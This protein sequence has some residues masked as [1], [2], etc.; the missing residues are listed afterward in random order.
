MNERTN[1]CMHLHIYASPSSPNLP[2]FRQS[3]PAFA[4]FINH[5][6]QLTTTPPPHLDH[7]F[8]PPLSLGHMEGSPVRTRVRKGCR[9]Q[10]LK[11]P[12]SPLSRQLEKIRFQAI[13]SP[14]ARRSDGALLNNTTFDPCD[15][16][17]PKKKGCCSLISLCVS[18]GMGTWMLMDAN[19]CNGYSGFLDHAV[20][21]SNCRCFV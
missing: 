21:R 16:D 15:Q 14:P 12:W 9:S 13:S 17:L 2:N 11:G 8:C 3:M 18:E 10:E 5:Q 19:G 1:E 7:S 6:K 20:Y 4:V